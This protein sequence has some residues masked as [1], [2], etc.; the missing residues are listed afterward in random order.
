MCTLKID[1]NIMSRNFGVTQER[2][3][4]KSMKPMEFA[5]N[6]KKYGLISR[7]WWQNS[8]EVGFGYLIVFASANPAA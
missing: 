6:R 8:R 5:T 4:S 7:H 3:N 1:P 2:G